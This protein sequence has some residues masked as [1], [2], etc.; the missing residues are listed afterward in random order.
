MEFKAL[1]DYAGEIGLTIFVFGLLTWGYVICAQFLHPDWITLPFSH[2]RFPPF[3][4]RM[5][6]VGILSF[7]AAAIGFLTWQIQ[8]KKPTTNN[9]RRKH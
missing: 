3:N 6:E 9:P 8:A 4:W 5:D 2:L 7:A 1:R